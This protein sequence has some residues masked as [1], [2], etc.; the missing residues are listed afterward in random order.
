RP[1]LYK[2]VQMQD[3]HNHP[4]SQ[5]AHV[6]AVPA[7]D[8]FENPGYVDHPQTKML[9][10]QDY[11]FHEMDHLHDK[12]AIEA[13]HKFAHENGIAHGHDHVGA[14]HSHDDDEY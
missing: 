11:T 14:D 3:G 12:D 6:G 1:Q 13:A 9:A 5:H 8:D 2:W 7:P 10:E 4:H